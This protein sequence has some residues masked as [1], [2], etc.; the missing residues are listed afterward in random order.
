[1]TENL[2]RHGSGPTVPITSQDGRKVLSGCDV[3]KLTS[4]TG[5][6]FYILAIH[7]IQGMDWEKKVTPICTGDVLPLHQ[8]F[9]PLHN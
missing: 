3:M 9:Q 2:R 7:L 5:D 4:D 1:M 6:V 8:M